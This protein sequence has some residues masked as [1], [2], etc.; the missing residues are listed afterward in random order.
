[1]PIYFPFFP[2][3]FGLFDGPGTSEDIPIFFAISSSFAFICES[4]LILSCNKN[5]FVELTNFKKVVFTR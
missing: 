2:F 4:T 1:M 5:T 3:D